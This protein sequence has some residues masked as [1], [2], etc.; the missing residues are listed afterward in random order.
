MSSARFGKHTAEI[1]KSRRFFLFG[2]MAYVSPKEK[3]RK[4]RE[5]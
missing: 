3:A 2:E 5:K 4:F 1:Q